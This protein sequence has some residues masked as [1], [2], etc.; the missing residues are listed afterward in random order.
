MRLLIVSHTP[1]YLQQGAPVGWGATVREIDY[2]AALFETVAHVAPLHDGDPPASALPYTATNVRLIPLRERGGDSLFAKLGV[3]AEMPRYLTTIRRELDNCDV[4]QVRC[5]SAVGLLSL[6]L[7][8]ISRRPERRWIK[9]AGNWRPG[10]REPV[11]YALQRWLLRHRYHGGA[12]TVNGAWPA[13]HAHVHSFH[14]PCLTESEISEGRLL[15]RSK[16]LDSPLRLIFVGRLEEAKGCRE[17]LKIMVALNRSGIGVFLDMI[18][19]GP[20]SDVLVALATKSG[21]NDKIRFHGWVPRHELNSLYA[22]AHVLLL[23]SRTEGWP[24]VVSEGMAF[25]VVPV[26]SAVGSLTSTLTS[27]R[28]GRCLSSKGV[29][30]YVAAVVEYVRDPVRW[31][32]ESAKAIEEASAFTY[33]SYV[34]AVRELLRG[35]HRDIGS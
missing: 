19:D 15:G 4:I 18:G 5:P 8:G 22:V 7:L 9:Y 31:K 3:L 25:G 23:P 27:L 20:D 17:A 35:G 1:H 26:T 33:E 10:H 21:V 11:S 14:N 6:L 12:V 29:D 2:L 16:E 28:V 34:G 32:R 30:D 24:K 13:Q